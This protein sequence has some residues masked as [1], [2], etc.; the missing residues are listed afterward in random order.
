[1]NS[2][3]NRSSTEEQETHANF[4]VAAVA[5]DVGAGKNGGAVHTRFP[6]EP[7]GYLH[8]GHAKAM[9][10]NYTL[11]QQF[12]GKFNLRFDD[13]NPAKE[14][15][16]FVDAIQD[17]ANWL[18]CDWE[19]RL[20]FASDYFETLYG[21]AQELIRA[22]RAYVCDLS[23]EDTQKYRGTGTRSGKN[24][25][26][27]ERSI[28]E[29]LDLF[30]RMRAG[31]FPDGSR[32][33]KAKI[34]MAAA[35]MY[36][37]DPVMYRILRAH[38]HRTGDEWCI[39][40]TYDFTHGQ[41]DAIEGITHSCCSL[42]FE[43]HRPLYEWYLEHLPVPSQPRQI[44]FARLNL[45]YTVLSKRKLIKLVDGGHVSGWDDP[46]LLSLRGLRRRGYTPE[47]IHAFLEQVGVARFNSTVD[48]VQL[49]NALRNDLNRRA[50]RRMAVLRP[51]KVIITNFPEDHIEELTAINNP[52][53]EGAGTRRLPLT[54]E[55]Y[56]ERD[57][58]R[59]EAPRKYFRLAPGKEVRLR[60]G[61]CIT[62][63]DV[64]TDQVSGEVSELHCTYD[65]DT[66]GGQ[67]PD[68]RKVKGI[69]HWV[70]A[71]AA[72][73]AEVR[74]YDHLFAVPFPDKDEEGQED[75]GRTFLD[76]LNP[77]SLEVLSGCK[78]EPSLAGAQPGESFQFERLGYFCVDSVDSSPGQL[79]FN[80][81]VSLRDA[82]ARI[83]K[84]RKQ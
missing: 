20:C 48:M 55:I 74:L 43:I 23:P 35:N 14:D 38:H 32:T 47:A 24:S 5:A 53:D 68:G 75:S 78:L 34:D 80:R 45:T 76:R 82:W 29:N 7:N 31:E 21:Y 83:E 25:P 39:Y 12:G 13:T 49:E 79:A 77:D 62:C 37:R 67:T 69:I 81:S 63:T 8:I 2:Q 61:Y 33:L 42:E 84:Q 51:L 17:D 57:D 10:L 71:Q 36:L 3:S 73:N 52:E 15:E 30:T 59:L 19:E 26:F 58:F 66:G 4:V 1:M 54:R 40:P 9:W 50:E 72:C 44:E 60:Y 46:R 11:A 27:R 16:E 64:I 70:S 28:E 56:I 6:P 65:P 41:S 22:G 18:G